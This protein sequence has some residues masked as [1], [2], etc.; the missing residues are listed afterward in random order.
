MTQGGWFSSFIGG[1]IGIGLTLAT[2]HAQTAPLASV[3]TPATVSSGRVANHT[4]ER[5]VI[6]SEIVEAGAGASWL[7]LTFDDAVLGDAPD[8]GRPTV[9]I[10]TSLDDGAAQIL[11]A[12]SLLHWRNTTAYFNGDAVRLDVIADPGA[13]ASLI[14]LDSITEGVP[15]GGAATICGPEDDRLP[16]SDPRVG[17]LMPIVCTAWLID[18]PNRTFLSA[19]HCTVGGDADIVQFNVPDSDSG[20]GLRHPGPEDQYPVDP[21]SMQDLNG[22]LGNDWAY[23]GCFPNSNTGLTPYEAQGDFFVLAADPAPAPGATIRITGHGS[24]QSPPQWNHVQQTHTG[25]FSSAS[26]TVMQYATDTT[27][28]N[29]GSPVINEATGEAIAIHTNGGCNAG[30][31]AN[32]GCGVLNAGLLNALANP[33]GVCIPAQPLT[34]TFPDGLPS[35]I[36]N[37]S[38]VIRVEVA[39]NEAAP[40]PGTGQLHVD[41]DDDGVF[42]PLPMIEI[43]PNV[44]DAAFPTLEC[45]ATVRYFFTAESDEGEQVADLFDPEDAAHE[46]TAG[47]GLDVVFIDDFEADLLW[48]VENGGGLTD[49]AWERGVP[50]GGGDRGDPPFDAD[51]SGQCYL[52]DN[53]DGNSDVDDG[54]T[55]LISPRLDASGLPD[56]HVSYRRW[57]SN[58]AGAAPMADIFV[59]DISN[60]NG[61]TW[62]NL[63]TIG[64]D[65]DEVNGGWI[66]VSIRIA[67]VL[68]PTDAVRVRFTASDLGDGSVVEAGVD[69]VRINRTALGVICAGGL[70][71][72][73]DGDGDVDAAD[74][75]A[76]LAAWG[77]GGPD[78]DLDLDGDVDAADLALLL[79][80]WTG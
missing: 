31:G 41:G 42:D 24:D 45:G 19:G 28:G 23:F 65:G 36:D 30:G 27:G 14:T 76:L 34:F 25:P 38:G 3:T 46:A 52:T 32:S 80:G 78:G 63:E 16:S 18:D 70:V 73:L 56:A 20:G 35:L 47:V 12:E 72:D 53:V 66:P 7:R 79:A 8:G 13:A 26:G 1:G 33:Q 22:G 69:D 9:L 55:T 54:S 49:G 15:V 64:P 58:T 5:R 74:L 62:T 17:R 39:A 44:Y 59:I 68:P 37:E 61:L 11:D 40:V 29:S 4:P 57:Y 50:I 67:D 43:E 2:A 21:V 51:G 10:V 77:S 60:D 75:A 71:G 6:W 48:S